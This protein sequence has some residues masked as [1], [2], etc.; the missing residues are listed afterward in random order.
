MHTHYFTIVLVLVLAG[1][2][3]RG[4]EQVGSPFVVG[5]DVHLEGR[6]THVDLTPMFVDGDAEITVVSEGFGTVLVRIPAGE[7]Q[8][9]ATRV[10]AYATVAA[11][12]DVRVFGRATGA[13]ELT[14]CADEAHFFEEADPGP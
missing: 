12:D 3:G 1:C 2:T 11:G 10:G 14:V 13:R 6:V 7:S 5:D 4:D 9:P 8:C